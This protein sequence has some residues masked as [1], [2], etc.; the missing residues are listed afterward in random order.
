MQLAT[1][2]VLRFYQ[3]MMNQ[4]MESPG[5]CCEFVDL[6]RFLLY[7]D[8]SKTSSDQEYGYQPIFNMGRRPDPSCTAVGFSFLKGLISKSCF[9]ASFLK[10]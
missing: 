6:M 5:S 8:I 7:N 2:K 1:Q 3:S 4:K 10:L 9:L